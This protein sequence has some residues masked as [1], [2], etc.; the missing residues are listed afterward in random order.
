MLVQ[1]IVGVLKL[2]V[3][4][5]EDIEHDQNAMGQAAIVVLGA[6]ILGGI[7]S[8]F[9]GLIIGDGFSSRFFGGVITTL[10]SW[11]IWSALTYFV[12][13][14]LFD[15]K[16][17]LGEMLRVIG[18]A[19]APQAFGVIPCLGWLVGLIWAT[20]T[21][22]VAVRQGLDID[23][24]RAALTIVVGFFGY[25][26]VYVTLLWLLGINIINTNGLVG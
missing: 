19:Q 3:A 9:W 11:P 12:G 14:K 24:M 8:G 26:I 2:N 16:A 21:G 23:N 25:I 22:F 7:G 1:R 15:G 5:Y 6:A 10:I 20:V 4:T 13:T 17:D 18:F